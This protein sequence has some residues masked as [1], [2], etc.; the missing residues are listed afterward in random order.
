MLENQMWMKYGTALEIEWKQSMEEGKDVEGLKDICSQI[1]GKAENENWEK[2]AAAV[3]RRMLNAPVRADYPYIEPSDL[4]SIR[5][6][7]PA[8][9]HSFTNNL[10]PEELKDK[11]AG[12]WIG[13]IS[14]CLLGK[15]VEG[16]RRKRLYA[17]LKGT[18]NYPMHKYICENEF[19]EELKEQIE[20]D[21]LEP[22][23]RCY[24]DRIGGRAPV[25]DDTNYTVFA[26]KL[27]EEYGR[28]F[29]PNDVLEAWLSWI[30]MFSTCTAERV[31]Y[32]NAA[33]G[34][35]APETATVENPYREWI[36]AQIRGD[37]F[38]YINPADPEAA[39]AM[40]WR[41]ASISHVK[42]GIYGEMFIAA[43]IAAAPVCGDRIKVVE[44]GLDEIPEKCR[45]RKEIDKVLGWYRDGVDAQEAIER[46]HQAYD[47]YDQHDWCHTNS[48][49]MIVVTAL[50]YGE[51]DLG[52][53]ICLA[54]GAAFDTDCNGATAG[55]IVGMM[56]GRSQIP[57][58]WYEC[59]HERLA[60]SISGYND[61]TVEQLT[62]KTMELLK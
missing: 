1:A 35:Y 37:F 22:W 23:Q 5:A 47:E 60:T 54:V 49:A 10:K 15:P 19:S 11:I 6:E 36:G 20:Y 58:Y 61:V 45:L 12:A 28:D 30:P 21:N 29:R 24:A 59:Y 62:E 40:A 14:G 38:G 53:T 3:G 26:L 27:I 7:A 56:A 32:R 57:A 43:M 8:R 2:E 4:K 44:A 55:S 31:A 17:L 18:D 13:R 50:L 33:A 52:K 48:N 16:F 25:D 46:I 42:N 9:R 34:L 51:G 39:A 41:D